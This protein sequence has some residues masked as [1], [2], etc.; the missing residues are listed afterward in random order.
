[1]IEANGV[2]RNR[3]TQDN[4]EP[5]APTRSEI[6]GSA[7]GHVEATEAIVER[8]AIRTLKAGDATISRSTMARASF[9]RGTVRQSSVGV[10]IAK[11]VACDEVHTAILAAPVVRGEVHTWLD[12]RTAVALGL[13]IAL[14]RALLGIIGQLGRRLAR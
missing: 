2:A 4:G 10:V 13:G 1:M 3:E 7:V 12:L 14:G 11:G 9:E 6:R 8:S 5:V